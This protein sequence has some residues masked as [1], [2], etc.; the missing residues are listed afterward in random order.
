[1]NGTTTL[2]IQGPTAPIH[3]LTLFRWASAPAAPHPSPHFDL[4][5]S[6]YSPPPPTSSLQDDLLP[7]FLFTIVSIPSKMCGAVMLWSTGH[8]A[9]RCSAEMYCIE[10]APFFCQHNQFW[11]PFVERAKQF[12]EYQW[13]RPHR[14]FS[15]TG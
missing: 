3:P 7:S 9:T 1:M 4:C 5:A 2:L 11:R 8:R 10:T 6:H 15:D 14:G 13:Y 12:N